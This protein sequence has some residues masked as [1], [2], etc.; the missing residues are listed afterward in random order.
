MYPEEYIQYLVHF[1]GDR[2]YFECHEILEEYWKQVDPGNK[3]SI[4][5]GFIQLAVSNYHYRRGNI[6][7]AKKTLENALMIFSFQMESIH[8]F[9]INGH[10][11]LL[12]VRQR[13]SDI[14]HSVPYK[15]NELP[16]T[17]PILLKEC[18][19]ACDQNGFKWGNESD[20][21]IE[22]IVHRHK[23]RDRTSVINARFLAM[24]LRKDNG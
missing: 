15:S 9:G 16:I 5:V 18:Q 4:L 20:L 2:D 17:D 6:Q 13:L 7:G 11:L 8:S 23:L 22:D 12:D 3:N 14:S 1:H 24:K 10:Q 19:I 21:A